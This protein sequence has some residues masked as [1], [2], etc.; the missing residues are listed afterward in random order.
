[1]SD[2]QEQPINFYEELLTQIQPKLLAHILALVANPTDAKDVLQECNRIILDKIGELKQADRFGSW[3]YRIAYFQSLSFLKK[4]KRHR[5]NFSETLLENIAET[6]E[7]DHRLTERNFRRLEHCLSKMQE[8]A[9]SVVCDFYYGKMPIKEIAV[10]RQLAAN[11][12][13]QILF[14][15]RKALFECITQLEDRDHG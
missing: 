3:A 12:V 6:N 1:M 5:L 14:R 13:A 11:H 15:A 8:K 4:R 10:K 2:P 7:R 9:R